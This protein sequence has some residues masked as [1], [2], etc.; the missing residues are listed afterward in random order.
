MLE[1]H[2][3]QKRRPVNL[4]I[5]EGILAHAKSL[6]LNTSRAA[7]M[8]ILEAIKQAQAEQWKERHKSSIRAYNERVE[9]VGVLLVPDW[10]NS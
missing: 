6:K 9:G 8:G 1:I 3:E 7:E 5:D 10:D 4:T 2:T